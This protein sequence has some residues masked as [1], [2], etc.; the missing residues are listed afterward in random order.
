MALTRVCVSCHK[1]RQTI[2][3]LI[4]FAIAIAF[5]PQGRAIS[6]FIEVAQKDLRERES[7][8][9][10]S[11]PQIGSRPPRCEKRCS[12]CEH[13]EAVQVPVA[14]QI[15]SHTRHYYSPAKASTVVTNS[16]SDD[17]SNYKP[18]SWKCK[19]GDLLFNP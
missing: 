2:L 17:L 5:T 9:V 19:C 13:C 4:L 14:S 8:T 10:V 3:C 16:R 11:K 12:T 15:Q 7:I 6:S 1:Y 18:M